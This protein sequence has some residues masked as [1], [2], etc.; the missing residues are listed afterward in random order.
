MNGGRYEDFVRKIS[1]KILDDIDISRDLSDAEV[2]GCIDDALLQSEELTASQKL[3]ARKQIFDS[4]RR[5]DAIQDLLEDETVTEIMVNGTEGIFYERQGKVYRWER[6]FASKDK[7]EDVIQQIVA[8]VNRAVNTASPIVDARLPDGSRVNAVLPPAAPYGP[9]L[10]IRKFAGDVITMRK[11]IEY[12]SL[13]EECAAYLEECVRKRLNIFI[14]GGTGSG[15]TTMLGALSR[16][17]PED[18]RI[19]TVEDSLELR[20]THENL[21]RLE[22]R[23]AGDDG[24][25]EIS[26]RDLIRTALR[27]RPDR[28]IV[29]E[30]RGP[31]ALDMLQAMNT[32]HDGSM[33]TGHANSTEDMLSRIET[34]V[35]MGGELPLYAVRGQIGSAIDVMVHLARYE[36]GSRKI[37]EISRVAGCVQGEIVLEKVYERAEGVLRRVGKE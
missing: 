30:V 34:M 17:I 13:D 18:A 9:I 4:F 3:R 1:G 32:G 8:R 28:L 16:F 26:I 31:E 7:L 12:G 23:A 24:D 2:R 25:G 37:S 19:I 21:V 27:M 33:S 15:K 29:G 11:L 14:S 36:D 10:T 5:L 6:T 35:L 20:L 22:A